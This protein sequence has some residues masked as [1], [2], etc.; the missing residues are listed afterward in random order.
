MF[1]QMLSFLKK[2]SIISESQ[3]GFREKHSTK[4][5]IT[6]TISHVCKALNE[7]ISTIALFADISKRLIP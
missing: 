4:M 5:A 2:Y 3:F 1:N 7:D 6:N